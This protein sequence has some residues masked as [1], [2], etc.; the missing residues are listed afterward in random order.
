MKNFLKFGFLFVFLL[1]FGA[2]GCTRV[3]V[4][5]VGLKV[6]QAGSDRGMQDIPMKTGWVFYNPLFTDI[7]E[8]PTF[9]QTAVWTHEVTESTPV[10]E[11]MTFNSKDGMVFKADV[12]VSYHLEADKAAHF[13]VKYKADDI[14][15]FTHGLMR[16]IA[17]DEFN[18]VASTFTAEDIYGPK[19]EEFVKAVQTRI[20]ATFKESGIIVESLGFVGALRPPDQFV[21][22]INDKLTATQNAIKAENQ[23]RETKANAEKAVAEA[24]GKADAMA[25]QNN[26]ISPQLL[27]LKDR[28]IA[29]ELARKWDGKMPSTMITSGDRTPLSMFI[30]K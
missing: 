19:K 12:N 6:S 3:G 23:L 29:L 26:S 8:Y 9:V 2:I 4:G 30:N 27:A 18:N 28:E 17:R 16:Q 14:S 5:S 21:Q 7:I 1:M 11:E 10:N 13:Y 25:V 24:K 20:N 15:H 22:A